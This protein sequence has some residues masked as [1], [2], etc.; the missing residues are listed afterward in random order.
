[1]QNVHILLSACAGELEEE[2]RA[3]EEHL[4]RINRL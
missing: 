3:L 4:E 1:M 2:V